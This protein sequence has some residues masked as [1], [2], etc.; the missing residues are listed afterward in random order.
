M[1]KRFF[2]FSAGLAAAALLAAAPLAAQE[3]SDKPISAGK[4]IAIKEQKKKSTL[5]QFKG[6]V[7]SCTIAAIT[8]RSEENERA[9][10]TFTYSPEVREKILAI[11]D[12]GGYQYGDRVTIRFEPGTSVAMKIKGKASKPV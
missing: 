1:T 12:H 11:I 7:V 10:R 4:P 2:L 9:L 8:V 3:P 5:E 6:E